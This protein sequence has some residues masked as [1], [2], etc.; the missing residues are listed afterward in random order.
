MVALPPDPFVSVVIPVYHDEGRLE[1]MLESLEAQTWSS[2]RYEVIVVDNGDDDLAP[3]VAP[4]PHATCEYE[5]RLGSFAARN[6][7]AAAARGDVLAFT[8]VDGLTEPGWIRAGVEALQAQGGGQIAG[9]IEYYVEN[10]RRLTAFDLHDLAWGT[11]QR[12]LVRIGCAATGN[13]FVARAAFEE[14]GGFDPRLYSCGDREFTTRLVAAGHP[15]AY[16]GKARVRHPTRSSLLAFARRRRR[17]AG[18]H[19]VVREIYAERNQAYRLPVTLRESWK[20]ARSTPKPIV[21]KGL[22]RLRFLCAEMLL[23]AITRLEFVR[24]AL[25][26]KPHR[27]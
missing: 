9:D 18:G 10:D 27:A 8:D 1:P 16:S 4:F 19:W 13:T 25:G 6:R 14:V 11:P 7:G 24:L 26:G 3:R 5:K 21:A 22:N 2:D 17:I 20:R 23:F 15:L 12:A